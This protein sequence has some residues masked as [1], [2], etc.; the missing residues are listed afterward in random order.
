MGLKTGPRR[1]V[2]GMRQRAARRDKNESEI[3]RVLREAGAS[4][5]QL[6]DRGLPDLLIGYKG[7]NVLV[8]VKTARGKL[9]PDQEKFFEM[10]KGQ[11]SVIRTIPD[12][13]GLLA[14]IADQNLQP[15]QAPFNVVA[16]QQRKFIV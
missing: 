3:I 15:M 13:E 12:A 1:L 14:G 11:A 16:V 10:W 2:E 9:T 6:D 4:V 8:E 7:V 5:V